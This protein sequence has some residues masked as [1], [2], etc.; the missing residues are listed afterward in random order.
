[1]TREAEMEA[2]E[3]SENEQASRDEERRDRRRGE[4]KFEQLQPAGECPTTHFPLPTIL[5]HLSH[6]ADTDRRG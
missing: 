2:N 5:R 3:A 6:R 4:A 1:M